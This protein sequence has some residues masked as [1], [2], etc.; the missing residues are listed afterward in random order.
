MESKETIINQIIDIEQK[1]FQEVKSLEPAKCQSEIKTFRLMRWMSHSAVDIEVLKS[2]LN[3]FQKALDDGR[4][5]MTEKYG[6]MQKLIPAPDK[7]NPLIEKIVEIE[8]KQMKEVR[9]K[10]P[11][12]FTDKGTAFA[13]YFKC[14]LQTY[15]PETIELYHK[16]LEEKSA[17]NQNIVEERYNNLFQKLEQKNLAEKEEEL[18]KK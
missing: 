10:Y 12:V 18:S 15:S 7:E 6:R 2:W 13:N 5:L 8:E 16:M 1:M 9:V 3:D 4:N 11:H 17:N 14:E